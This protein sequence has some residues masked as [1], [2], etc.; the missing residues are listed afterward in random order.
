MQ[1][2]AANSYFLKRLNQSFGKT[3]CDHNSIKKKLCQQITLLY[4][5][6]L[7][8]SHFFS[9]VRRTHEVKE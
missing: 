5:L 6:T 1:S 3:T 4:I 2:C 7:N 8:I 9:D